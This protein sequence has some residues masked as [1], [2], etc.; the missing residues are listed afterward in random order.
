MR[1]HSGFRVHHVCGENGGDLA[2]N[3]GRYDPRKTSLNWL[4][5]AR[6]ASQS[7]PLQDILA[8]KKTNEMNAL[9]HKFSVAPMID[10]T[11]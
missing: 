1:V 10:G 11:D 3:R 6:F 4:A 5:R 2:S 8:T 7:N 9:D